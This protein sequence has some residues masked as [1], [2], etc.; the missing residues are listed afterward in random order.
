MKTNLISIVLTVI[1]FAFQSVSVQAQINLK[2]IAKSAVSNRAN[3]DANQAANKGLDEVEGIFKKKD[4]SKNDANKPIDDKAKADPSKTGAND[5]PGLQSFSKYDFIPGDKVI[6]FEDF[7]QDAVGDFP[8]LWTTD[9]AG[10]I[11][12]L[13]IGTGNWL[14]LNS[15]E[16]TYWFMKEIE[17]PQ[18]FILEMDIV[19][20]ADARTHCS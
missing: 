12:T 13:N 6:L 3:K 17:F 4:S 11:N 19:P 2:K 9:V 16:G 18:N 20:K 14:N 1:I 5:Q 7:S 10:E 15:T 8:A